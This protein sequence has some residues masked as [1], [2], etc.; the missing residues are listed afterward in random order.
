MGC[1]ESKEAK[2]LTQVAPDDGGGLGLIIP[3]S[4]K[5]QVNI[6]DDEDKGKVDEK[7]KL[8][9]KKILKHVAL[10]TNLVWKRYDN[11]GNGVIDAYEFS[12]LI[13]DVMAW[14]GEDSD[15]PNPYE[16]KKFLDQIDENGDGELDRDEFG[17]FVR[18]GL[19]LSDQQRMDF[20]ANSPMHARFMLFLENMII[21]AEKREQKLN[22]QKKNGADVKTEEEN[23]ET[24]T[25]QQT[26]KQEDNDT[27]TKDE[28]TSNNDN[29]G[30]VKTSETK[31]DEK[32]KKD[33]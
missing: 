1:G 9:D 18:D 14:D 23:G 28:N 22:T 11:D 6:G 2:K 17:H 26:E 15:K 3:D 29:D 24:E 32:E 31:D 8:S 19:S 33:D 13:G 20:A 7:G 21:V 27:S 16:V 30:D 10:I 25:E 5:D 4:M 12:T